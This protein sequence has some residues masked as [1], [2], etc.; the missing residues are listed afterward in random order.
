M[1]AIELLVMQG[2]RQLSSRQLIQADMARKGMS[3]KGSPLDG[4]GK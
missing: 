4:T 2:S 3:P 1:C